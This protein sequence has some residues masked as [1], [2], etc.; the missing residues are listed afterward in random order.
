MEL[1]RE[2][3]AGVRVLVVEPEE[4]PPDVLVSRCSMTSIV[5]ETCNNNN[6]NESR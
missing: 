5:S 3:K 4:K 2:H 1:K 6:N